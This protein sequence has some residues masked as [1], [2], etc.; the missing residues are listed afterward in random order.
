MRGRDKLGLLSTVAVM[1]PMAVIATWSQTAVA[2][3]PPASHISPDVSPPSILAPRNAPTFNAAPLGATADEAGLKAATTKFNVYVTYMNGSL[4]IAS[5]IA[6]YTSWVNMRV[7]PTGRERDVYGVSSVTDAATERAAAAAALTADPLLPD[8]DGAM[9]AYIAV[10]KPMA[11][12]LNEAHGYYDRKDYTEDGMAG[13]KV[14]HPRIAA[15]AGPF[16]A[17]RAR[18]EAVMRVEKGQLDAI[19]LAT[20]EKKEGRDAHWQIANVMMRAKLALDTLS[21]TSSTREALLVDVP[22]FEAA[23][24]A[25]GDAV[26][27]MDAY[28]LQHPKAFFV[29]ASE[30]DSLLAKLRGLKAKLVHTGGDLR[31]AAGFETTWIFNDYNMMVS[32][33]E[34]ALRV[35]E[36]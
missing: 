6:S 8:L 18:L 33:S 29:F 19:R 12:I 4:G 15:V 31:R 25:Y 35:G 5:S 24:A 14:L 28:A 16:L 36:E 22:T 17:A 2:Q 7:G 23:L 13:G 9:R 30:P 34:T 27:A 26:K 32:T 10:E 3:S 1:L 21:P 20:I 11:P